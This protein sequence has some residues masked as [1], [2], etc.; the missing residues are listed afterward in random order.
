MGGTRK[1]KEK[2]LKALKLDRQTVRNLSV[3]T[4]VRT[5]D[6]N[7]SP[8]LSKDVCPQPEPSPFSHPTAMH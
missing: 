6:S 7:G 4:G 2:K 5:G 3:R 1:M 8:V